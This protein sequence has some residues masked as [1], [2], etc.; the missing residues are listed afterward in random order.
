M[1]AFFIKYHEKIDVYCMTA[2]LYFSIVLVMILLTTFIENEYFRATIVL[3][4]P[5]F[6]SR[7]RYSKKINFYIHRIFR[8]EE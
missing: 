3:I 5:T 2:F 7:K 4:I 1:K 6:F 8:L